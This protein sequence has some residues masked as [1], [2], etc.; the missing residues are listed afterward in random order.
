MS[1]EPRYTDSELFDNVI[2]RVSALTTTSKSDAQIKERALRALRDLQDDH[3]P[4]RWGE[5]GWAIWELVRVCGDL[6][7]ISADTTD[8]RLA[9]DELMRLYEARWYQ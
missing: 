3:R 6:E 8:A 5:Y 7:R 4:K 2:A 1:I 9:V